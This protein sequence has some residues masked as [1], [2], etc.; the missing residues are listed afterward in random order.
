M[1]GRTLALP[2]VHERVR[3][4][5]A[6]LWQA[7]S[8]DWQRISKDAEAGLRKLKD[9]MGSVDSMVIGWHENEI[10]KLDRSVDEMTNALEQLH[11]DDV[12]SKERR[13]DVDARSIA[14]DSV[15]EAK[16]RRE[17]MATTPPAEQ[18]AAVDSYSA[19][20]QEVVEGWRRY[21]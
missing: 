9:E 6:R 18:R 19:A 7:F 1:R 3:V 16:R 12:A 20:G 8:G 5:F 10:A 17:A 21:S 13:R 2:T 4:D 11:T 15:A 14:K